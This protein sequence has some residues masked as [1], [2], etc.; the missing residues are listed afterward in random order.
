VCT[1]PG[2]PLKKVKL[3]AARKRSTAS[4]AIADVLNAAGFPGEAQHTLVSIRHGSQTQFAKAA[5]FDAACF[6]VE[7]EHLAPVIPGNG[8][9][10]GQ[11][12]V[13]AAALNAMCARAWAAAMYTTG[14]SA[15]SVQVVHARTALTV[16][17]HGSCN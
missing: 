9:V 11:T 10:S 13:M 8:R 4:K 1:L 17:C 15:A 12:F 16:A 14:Q 3:Q 7:A 5:A 6:P 2:T